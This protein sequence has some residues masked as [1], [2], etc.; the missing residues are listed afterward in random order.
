M[1]HK[2]RVAWRTNQTKSIP[3]DHDGFE[4]FFGDFHDLAKEFDEMHSSDNGVSDSDE[5]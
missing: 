3:F 1:R 4:E 2:Q 5:Y